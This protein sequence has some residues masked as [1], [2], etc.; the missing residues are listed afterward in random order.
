M[1]CNRCRA[2]SSTRKKVSIICKVCGNEADVPLYNNNR[3]KV[4]NEKLGTCEECGRKIE[5]TTN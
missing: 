4:C 1:F 3:C 5:E 2:K